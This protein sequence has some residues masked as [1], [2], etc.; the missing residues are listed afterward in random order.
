MRSSFVLGVI[1][2]LLANTVLAVGIR[3]QNLRV[4]VDY[5]PGGRAEFEYSAIANAGFTQDY[6][7]R[8]V[9]GDLQEHVMV[10]PLKILQLPDGG[11]GPFKAIID[12]P[13]ELSTPGIHPIEIFVE[14]TMV[15]GSGGDHAA[16]ANIGAKVA[17]VAQIMVR[18]LYPLKK[19][20][21]SLGLSNGDVHQQ[22]PL[23]ANVENWGKTN[24]ANVWA[25]FTILDQNNTKIET[26][27]SN[28][29][30]LATLE[31]KTLNSLIDAVKYEPGEYKVNAIIH[32]DETSEEANGSFRIGQ[33]TV[34]ILEATATFKN[35]TI[36]Q[37]NIKLKNQWNKELANV[38]AVVRIGPSEVQT[39]T[40]MLKAWEE[41]V[42]TGY[43]D[44]TGFDIGKHD[45]YIVV[46]Y[47]EKTSTAKVTVEIIPGLEAQT[48]K[49]ISTATPYIFGL[50]GIVAILII[51]NA[52]LIFKLRKHQ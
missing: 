27:R 1:F 43:W 10:E 22:I 11:K 51:L 17:A 25:D 8:V 39:P 33:Q 40:V 18:V 3:G 14:E 41:R 45:A 7:L 12:F 34:E 30:P 46:H 24:F 5:V 38:Y 6:D 48:E 2:L 23:S 16:T 47:L 4:L 15:R 49:P 28:M 26:L 20:V 52:V 44:T 37:F 42:L 13:P 19:L 32:G 35:S 31:A 9:A 29:V 36:N 21:V 50:L